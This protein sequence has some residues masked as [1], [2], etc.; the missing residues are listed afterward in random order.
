M[1]VNATL[2]KRYKGTYSIILDLGYQ[3]DPET[4]KLKRKQNG[5]RLRGMKKP[6][7]RS[8]LK[9]CTNTTPDNS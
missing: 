7:K 9:S 2:K 1:G 4:G 3:K 5:S 6:L 8:A